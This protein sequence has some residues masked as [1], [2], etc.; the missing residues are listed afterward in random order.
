VKG[1]L[2]LIVTMSLGVACGGCGGAGDT[3]RSGSV[4][5]IGSLLVDEDDDDTAGDLQPHGSFTNG[6]A[7]ADY[8]ND[9][10]KQRGFYDGDDDED[11]KFG[12]A[13]KGTQRFALAALAK[14]YFAAGAESDGQTACS[15]LTPVFAKAVVEDY[16]H[17]SAGPSYLKAATTCPAVMSSLF[18]HSHAQ[19]AVPI[20]VVAIRVRGP[21]ALVLVGSSA[22][23]ARELMAR[24][25][26]GVWRLMDLLGLSL[27]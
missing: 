24:R 13:A 15:L 8:D 6:D 2:A 25:E 14:R 17:G 4:A 10:K 20:V 21:E 18:Q 23:P 7:D 12:H 3:T 11:R 19:L 26:A 22:L 5:G 27:L 9:Y 1:L 16:G